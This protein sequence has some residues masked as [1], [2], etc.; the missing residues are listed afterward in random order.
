MRLENLTAVFKNTDNMTTASCRRFVEA[1]VT[2]YQT[3][4]N[5]I[6]EDVSR[7]IRGEQRDDD[8]NNIMSRGVN[9]PSSLERTQG[10]SV[11]FPLAGKFA[12]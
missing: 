7:R 11:L 10:F 6:L 9:T 8:D 1:S 3:A 5:M 4:R 12:T 2:L